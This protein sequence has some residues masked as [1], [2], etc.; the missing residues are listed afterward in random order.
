[1][2]CEHCRERT[3]TTHITETVNGYTKE[4]NLCSLCAAELNYDGFLNGMG[5]N[6]FLNSVF[7]PLIE[8]G[9]QKKRCPLCLKSSSEIAAT[10]EAGCAECYKVFKEELLSSITRIHGKARHI[11]KRPTYTEKGDKLSEMEEKLRQAIDTEDFETAAKLRDEIREM[12][13]GEG[14]E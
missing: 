4:L 8:S 9:A 1:M 3:A 7:A 11:G 10:G 2:I 12:K 14:N 5:V 13:G 6:G